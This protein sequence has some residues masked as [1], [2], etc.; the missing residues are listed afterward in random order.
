MKRA[1][2]CL[3]FWLCSKTYNGSTPEDAPADQASVQYHVAFIHLL[4]PLAHCGYFRES[5]ENRIRDEI[6]EHARTGLLHIDHC[7]R[8]YSCRYGMPITAF[9]I[10]HMGD[11]L[12]QFSA[13]DP[14]APDV[15]SFVSEVMQQNQTGFPLCGPLQQM[16]RQGAEGQGV[17]LHEDAANSSASSSQYG[18][19]SILDACTRL[20]Y[21]QPVD[22]IR[23]Y[24]DR[25]IGEQ[26]HDEWSQQMSPSR[27]RRY[28]TAERSM[29]ITSVLNND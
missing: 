7:K 2:H 4:A 18:L 12:I 22:Q 10:L 21:A 9:C 13:D 17:K 3:T 29:Q 24:I 5:D 26:W 1:S 11:A 6:V 8:L 23:R 20:E 15:V 16:F 25:S 28:S 14:P 19:D 27:T